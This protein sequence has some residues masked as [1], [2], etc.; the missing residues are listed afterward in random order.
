MTFKRARV[1]VTVAT[2][3]TRIGALHIGHARTILAGSLIAQER[4]CPFDLRL[5]GSRP[6]G[7]G[8]ATAD[9]LLSLKDLLRFLQIECRVYFHLQK[10]LPLETVASLTGLAADRLEAYR[11]LA[12]I[13]G[14]PQEGMLLAVIEDDVILYAPSLIIRGAEF[15]NPIQW[16]PA[17]TAASM[18]RQMVY[19]AAVFAALGVEKREVNVPLVLSKDR[20]MSKSAVNGIAWDLLTMVSPEAARKYLIA[21]LLNPRDPLSALEDRFAANKIAPAHHEWSW[22]TWA[23]FV[24]QN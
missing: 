24:T 12:Q 4:G 14:E 5:D 8:Q 9:F 23:T 17:D 10:P 1:G 6:D 18:G 3:A 13:I 2:D 7:I 11:R 20:K 16:S 15:A 19:E 22:E 21:S